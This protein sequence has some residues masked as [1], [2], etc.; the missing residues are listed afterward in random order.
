M[1]WVGGGGGREKRRN[2]PYVKRL[3]DVPSFAQ[4]SQEG[5]LWTIQDRDSGI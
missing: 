4:T 3:R 5:D 2:G 1:G